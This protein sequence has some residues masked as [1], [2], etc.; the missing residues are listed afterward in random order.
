[1]IK[2]QSCAARAEKCTHSVLI[3]L[4]Y[5]TGM[6]SMPVLMKAPNLSTM[7]L[8][9]SQTFPCARGIQSK[10]G[11]MCR[12]ACNIHGGLPSALQKYF[13]YKVFQPA[14]GQE[15][16]V[17]SILHGHD[18]YVRIVQARAFVCSFQ[19]LPTVTE[20]VPS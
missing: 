4:W 17:F 3:D 11:L 7:A 16:A 14:A 12:D 6:T 15:T 20:H 19:H 8:L 10:P 5:L 9:C 1:M 2:A 18:T 13:G